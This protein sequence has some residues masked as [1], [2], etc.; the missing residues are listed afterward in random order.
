MPVIKTVPVGWL[1]ALCTIANVAP[2]DTQPNPVCRRSKHSAYYIRITR[3]KYS[4]W[5]A[6][7][8]D[9]HKKC[10]NTISIS[11][12]P[13]R[14][15]RSAKMIEIAHRNKKLQTQTRPQ[16]RAACTLIV[17]S[18]AVAALSLLLTLATLHTTLLCTSTSYA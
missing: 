13:A 17:T 9:T 18:R 10:T 14:P 5:Q 16:Q 15:S 6:N 1:F 4:L 7:N 2:N 11:T 8:T 12:T 3:I